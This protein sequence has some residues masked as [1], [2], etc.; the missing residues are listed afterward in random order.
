M[1]HMQFDGVN[2][3]LIYTKFYPKKIPLTFKG[4]LG[5]NC[6]QTDRQLAI[7]SAGLAFGQGSAYKNSKF[8]K[9]TTK[10]F[11]KHRYIQL[12]EAEM[13]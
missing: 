13:F 10:G 8:N 1:L 12:K 5:F 4:A 3:R 6:L 7:A 9:I 11:I 2:I